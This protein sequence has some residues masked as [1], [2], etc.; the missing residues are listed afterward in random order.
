VHRLID[1][2]TRLMAATQLNVAIARLMELTSLLRKVIDSGLGPADPAVREGVEALARLLSCFAPF[3]AEEAWERLEP[4]S[5]SD[6]STHGRRPS[7]RW[8]R[9]RRSPAWCKSPARYATAW[10]VPPGTVEDEL[11]ERALRS[12]KVIYALDGTDVLKVIIRA[13]RL[14]NVVLAR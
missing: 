4:A 11:R 6:P 12:E 10:R 9:R 1:D 7:R 5:V 2:T 3:T 8:S 13:P 14:V